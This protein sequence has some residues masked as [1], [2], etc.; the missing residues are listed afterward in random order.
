MN[1]PPTQTPALPRDP[2]P[3]ATVQSAS[4]IID[5]LPSRPGARDAEKATQR[6]GTLASLAAL[7]PGDPVQAML[8]VHIAASHY[9]AMNSSAAPRGASCRSTC[10]CAPS[11]GRSRCA[12]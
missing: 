10:T 9:A 7:R 3:V 12:G 2:G 4:A 11:A 6:E 1:S 8:A 5:G